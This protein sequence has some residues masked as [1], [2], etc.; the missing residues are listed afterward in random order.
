ME[1]MDDTRT[2]VRKYQ[3][4]ADVIRQPR[5]REVVAFAYP[6]HHPDVKRMFFGHR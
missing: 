4:H 6:Y 2:V 3:H 5:P 1:Y